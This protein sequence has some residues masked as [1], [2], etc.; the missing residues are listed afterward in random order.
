MAILFTNRRN[1]GKK[2]SLQKF[3]P[4]SFNMGISKEAFL[5]TGGFGKIH[6]GEDPDL[7]HRIINAG[8][9]T[10]FFPKVFVYHKRRISWSKFYTQVKKFGLV[11]PIISLWHPGAA[12]ITFWFP[13]LFV[14]Y[15]LASVIALLFGNTI[16]ISFLLIYLALVFLESLI[17]NKSLMISLFTLIALFIQFFGYGI[18]F[19]KS[20]FVIRV[21]K[22]QPQT[23]FPQLFF[24]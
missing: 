23:A 20:T 6:P 17:V 22:K 21:L 15:T 14:F 1:P 4:R 16:F 2:N 10:A 8:F 7:S 24:K 18:A 9:K 11:R 3:E 13:T 19:L 12:K 5:A